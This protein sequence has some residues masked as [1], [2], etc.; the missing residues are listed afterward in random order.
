MEFFTKLEKYEG[1]VPGKADL[2]NGDLMGFNGDLMGFNGN[3]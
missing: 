1:A 2:K 3:Y